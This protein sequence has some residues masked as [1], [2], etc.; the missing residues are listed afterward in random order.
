VTLN[1]NSTVSVLLGNGNGIFQSAVKYSTGTALNTFALGDFNGDGNP[2]VAGSGYSS[3]LTVLLGNGDGT[4]RSPVAYF[5]STSF[6]SMVSSDFNGDGKLDLAALNNSPTILL[7][8]GDGTFQSPVTVPTNGNYYSFLAV[9]DMNGDGK[10]DLVASSGNSAAISVFLG[11]GDGTFQ[12]MV[13]SPGGNIGNPMAVSLGDFNGDGR[14]DVALVY[15]LGIEVLLG[16]GDGTLQAPIQTS[17]STGSAP[18][19]TA[20]TADFDGDGKLDIAY[21]GYYSN[22]HTI[23]FGN[24]DG[25]FQSGMRFATDGYAATF[26]VADFDGDGRT[27]FTVANSNS[28]TVNVF[29]GGPWFG[30]N[31]SSAHSGNFIAG[32]TG[33]YRITVWKQGFETAASTVTVVDALPAGLSATAISGSGWNCTLSS[34]SCTRSDALINN[35][36]YPV[37]SITVNVSSGLSPSTV[38]NLASVNYTTTSALTGDLTRIVSATTTSLTLSANPLI[39]G[40]AVTL[41]A[42]VV[43]GGTGTVAFLDQGNPIG[44]ALLNSGQ[45]TLSTTLLPAGVRSLSAT[46]SG[47]S[48]HGPSSSAVK[49]LTVNAALASGLSAA[50][51][52]A[53]GTGST[54]VAVGDF[55]LDGKADLVTA[56]STANNISVLLG[57]GDGTFRSH[58]DY[59]VGTNP[60]SVASGD[61]NNDGN[62]D[63]A[64]AN[65]TG[66]N[67]SVL[68]GKGD[69]TFQPAVNYSTGNGPR[70]LAAGDLN[71]DGVLDLVVAN[72][73]DSTLTLLFGSGDGTFHAASS[74]LYVPSVASVSLGDFN[75]YG[76]VDIA[77]SPYGYV[78]LGNGDGTFQSSLYW[79]G[80]FSSPLAVGDLNGDG[81]LDVVAADYLG[82]GIFLG[83]GDGTQLSYQHYST[84]FTAASVAIADVNGD[85]KLDVVTA[86]PDSGSMGVLLGNGDGTLQSAVSYTVGSQPRGVA[87]ADFNG[88]GRTD[89]VVVNMGSGNVSVLLGILTP[90]F[91]INS[92]HTGYF[93][94]GQVGATYTITV[95]NAGPGI[96]SGTVTVTDTLP[97]GLTAT[98]I[99][100]TGWTCDL[101]TLTCTRS[102]ALAAGTSYPTITVTVNAALNAPT[103]VNNQVSVSGGGSPS[104]NF[105]DLTYIVVPPTCPCTIWNNSAV[106]STVDAGA[107]PG[108]E[109]GVKFRSDLS[110]T[111]TGLRFYKSSSNTG[112]HVGN[113]WSSNGTLLASAT[114]S[115]ESGSGW[116]QVNFATPVAVAANTVYVASYHTNVSH[117]SMNAGAF[118]SAGVDNLPL[119]ALAN[120]VSGGNGVYAY[121]AASAFP[122]NGSSANYWVDVVF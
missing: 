34:V 18:G 20:V 28:S 105:S 80:S 2:D 114:F 86:N 72:G 26:A 12:P 88:D 38:Q 46:Y 10:P 67:V 101:P 35:A 107:G 58:V 13:T 104:A 55:N 109:L 91:T 62:P 17:M 111:I 89:L 32:K 96:T 84:S 50:T 92:S 9:A 112:T 81:N 48:T 15:W 110:G 90:V 57:N 21:A 43:G 79:G 100:G 66:G 122:A 31:I 49:S 16:N 115:N 23:A 75:R 70:F 42:T 113:L 5:S 6:S 54:A 7:G 56:N 11:R 119:H 41:T 22:I 108:V 77:A 93:A 24:G 118:G 61:F 37:I 4:L 40:H 98:A 1:N 64:V 19:Y 69:G 68:L 102:D 117:F 65:Q 73:S 47:D 59:A 3:G 82:V 106:P 53:T 36:A 39:L 87:G 30:L 44:T 116:Q 25:T 94:P 60:V 33:T 121:S 76:N 71:S 74:T 99:T 97:T 52:Y 29:L 27:D 14:T 83:K 85:G 120:G 51:T 78:Y 45:A 8:N 63:I 95:T 103:P